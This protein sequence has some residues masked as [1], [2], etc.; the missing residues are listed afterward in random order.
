MNL[1]NAPPQANISGSKQMLRLFLAKRRLEVVS[2]LDTVDL[3]QELA[4]VFA[5]IM[6]HIEAAAAT[7]GDQKPAVDIFASFESRMKVILKRTKR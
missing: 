6:R 2:N 7:N 5:D 4:Y 3:E 1:L